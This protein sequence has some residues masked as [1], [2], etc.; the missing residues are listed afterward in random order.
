MFAGSPDIAELKS[1]RLAPRAGGGLAGRA[2][3]EITK[4]VRQLF[5]YRAF[6][7]EPQN[8]SWF[9]KSYGLKI[10]EPRLILIIGRSTVFERPEDRKDILLLPS[11]VSVYTYDDLLTLARERMFIVEG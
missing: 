11:E 6:F 9:E 8:R 10:Y 7:R 2:S 1:P 5:R 4:A 3:A